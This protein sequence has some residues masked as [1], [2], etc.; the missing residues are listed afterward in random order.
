M[1][2][3]LLAARAF[4]RSLLPPYP[5]YLWIG[6]VSLA[7]LAGQCVGMHLETP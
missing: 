3:V 7:F 4:G 6:W 2:R 5:T 1:T